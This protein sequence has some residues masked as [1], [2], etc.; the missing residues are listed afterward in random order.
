VKPAQTPQTAPEAPV[1]VEFKVQ[2]AGGPKGRRRAR[3]EESTAPSERRSTDPAVAS[4]EPESAKKASGDQIPRIRRLLVLGHYFENLVREGVVKDY[5]EIARLTGLSRARVT[6]ITNL[7]LLA[8]EIQEDFL[9]VPMTRNPEVRPTESALRMVIAHTEWRE[10][11]RA[12]NH[13]IL[14]PVP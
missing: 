1:R 2:F 4:P 8:P 5:A 7:I 13:T 10:Q 3:G 12:L 6:Q 14:P 11:R 9:N